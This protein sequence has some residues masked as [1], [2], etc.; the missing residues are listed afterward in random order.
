MRTSL[1]FVVGFFLI[2]GAANAAVTI[3]DAPT[4]HMQ[5]SAGACVPTAKKAFLNKTDLANMLAA[6]DIKV[7]TGNGAVS[8]TV[9]SSFSW[10]S[11][12]RLTL[13][14]YHSIAFRAAVIVAGTGSVTLTPDTAND[15]GTLTFFPGGSIDFWDTESSL[16]V[17]GVPYTLV[18]N[19]PTLAIDIGANPSGAYALSKNY[20]A[21]VDGIYLHAPIQTPFT[22]VFHGLGHTIDRLSIN[23]S[24]A[25][26]NV[27]LFARVDPQGRISNIALTSYS[28]S[29]VAGNIGGLVGDNR[30]LLDGVS[31][32]GG[33]GNA[34][35]Q[36]A[37]QSF[38]TIQH[39]QATVQMLYSGF[40]GGGGIVGYNGDTGRIDDCHATGSIGGVYA[41]GGIAATNAGVII[42]S[43]AGVDVETVFG[44]GLAGGLVGLIYDSGQIH[45]SFATGNVTFNG[46]QGAKHPPKATGVQI[47]GLAGSSQGLIADSYALGS[48]SANA[49]GNARDDVGG[50]V[51]RLNPYDGQIHRTYSTGHVSIVRGYLGGS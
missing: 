47:G 14:A 7:Y 37:G 18:S 38:G 6:S 5:C 30:G 11:A 39:S 16:I 2:A 34:E 36:I 42:N 15:G 33:T 25:E 29:G 3:S 35:G 31:A 50:L 22:G 26:E 27:G 13:E 19:I 1:S 44:D 46:T 48:V 49:R 17:S 28:V 40:A 10:T 32:S 8:I 41:G 9:N 4:K 45:Q 43:S 12:N 24:T 21:F 20:D 23:D 51:G